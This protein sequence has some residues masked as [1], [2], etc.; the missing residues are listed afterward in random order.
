MT[1][2]VGQSTTKLS[3]VTGE[4]LINILQVLAGDHLKRE[5]KKEKREKRKEKR[6]KRKEKREKKQRGGDERGR[7]KGRKE[8]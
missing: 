3:D 4:H 1:I 7:E 8:G 2:N 6:E 5:N